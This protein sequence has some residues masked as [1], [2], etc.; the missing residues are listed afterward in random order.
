MVPPSY[1]EGQV[2][3]N[4]RPLYPEVANI[5]FKVAQ[6]YGVGLY[7]AVAGNNKAR[8]DGMAKALPFLEFWTCSLVRNC[9]PW[10]L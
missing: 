1:M 10:Q 9:R 4:H 3:H 7:S 6:K 8:A 2:A 5:R